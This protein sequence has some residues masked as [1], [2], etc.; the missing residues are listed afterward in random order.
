M[1]DVNKD[2]FQLGR[3]WIL[4]MQSRM[5]SSGRCPTGKPYQPITAVFNIVDSF[6]PLR[7]TCLPG[8]ATIWK[9]LWTRIMEIQTLACAA[10][11][12]ISYVHYLYEVFKNNLGNQLN[13]PPSICSL[14]L[15]QDS[16]QVSVRSS[17]FPGSGGGSRFGQGLAQMSWPRFLT[18]EPDSL[19]SYFVKIEIL[20]QDFSKMT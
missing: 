5:S 4:H 20:C 8:L 11:T 17:L 3:Q 12:P 6:F 18:F 7:W 9:L 13:L 14:S 2:Y 15:S 16:R 19:T 10:Q 1:F